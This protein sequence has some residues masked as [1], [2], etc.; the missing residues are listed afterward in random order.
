MK[1]RISIT[2]QMPADIAERLNIA[3][4]DTSRRVLEAIAVEE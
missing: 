4:P 2:I 1:A 3:W